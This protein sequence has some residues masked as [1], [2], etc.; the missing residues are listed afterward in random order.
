MIRIS[1]RH[2]VLVFPYRLG[3][4]ANE[5][6]REK[7]LKFSFVFRQLFRKKWTKGKML[8]RSKI[9][10]LFVNWAGMYNWIPLLTLLNLNI[11]GGHFIFHMLI[12]S[13]FSLFHSLPVSDQWE[14]TSLN[15]A[16]NFKFLD[17][18]D[19]LFRFLQTPLGRLS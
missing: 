14:F 16:Q 2:A 18:F 4:A 1:E 10:L 17:F 7:M 11:Q 12:P 19:W 5:M 6:L 13:F 9:S 3:F 15:V 8:K